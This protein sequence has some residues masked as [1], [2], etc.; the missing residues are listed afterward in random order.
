MVGW[1]CPLHGG[2]DPR[3]R[4]NPPMTAPDTLNRLYQQALL[5]E[6]TQPFGRDV[7]LDATHRAPGDNPLCGDHLEM[8]LRVEGGTVTAAAFSGQACAICLASASLLC[9]HLPGHGVNELGGITQQLQQALSAGDEAAGPC[10]E[11]FEPLLAVAAFP[12]RMACAMLP[13]DTALKAVGEV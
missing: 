7:A 9:R 12:A 5:A 4:Y 3:S 6:S 8:L 11:G 2:S 10:P 1:S 13:L